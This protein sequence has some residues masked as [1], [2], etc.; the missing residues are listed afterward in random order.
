[1]NSHLRVSALIITHER[2]DYL[3]QALNSV[4]DQT[5]PPSEIVIV[6]DASS[7]DY[8]SVLEQFPHTHI[9]YHRLPTPSGANTARNIGVAI[10]Q[11]EVVAFLDDDDSWHREFISEHL[12][13]YAVGADAVVCGHSIMFRHHISHINPQIRVNE[14]SLRTG[15]AF[16][17]M[18]GFSAK[19]QHL[20]DIP[21]DEA[22]PNGQDWDLYVRF[23]QAKRV[24]VNIPKALFDYREHTENGIT[25]RVQKLTPA[26][27]EIRLQSALKHREWLGDYHFKRRVAQQ[28]LA[29]LPK[30]RH[31]AAWLATAIRHAGWWSTLTALVELAKNKLVRQ[32]RYR[33]G[34]FQ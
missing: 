15:N 34:A 14:Q 12:K 25:A 16:S 21:F 3:Y 13:A 17:G 9:R 11:Y 32:R 8:R 24:F 19:R 1:M 28:L 2:P 33:K 30:K 27:G 4:L 7:A 31:K 29:F 22:L 20:L 10:A 5:Y 18:S 6:D 26:Q 23:V